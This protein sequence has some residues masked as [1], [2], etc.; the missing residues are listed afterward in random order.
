MELL[1]IGE[2]FLD[3]FPSIFVIVYPISIIDWIS[4]GIETFKCSVNIDVELADVECEEDIFLPRI[5]IVIS[6]KT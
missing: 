6:E 4:D 1:P 5:P 2:A 3:S